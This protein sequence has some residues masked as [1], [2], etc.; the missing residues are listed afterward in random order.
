MNF[1]REQATNDNSNKRAKMDIDREKLSTQ[2][3]IAAKN[4]E[5][6]RENK[7]KYDVKPKKKDKKK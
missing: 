3:E 7:N 2:R 1:K 4:L 6:A 5:I